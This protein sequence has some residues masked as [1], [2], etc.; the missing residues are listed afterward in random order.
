[1]SLFGLFP[2]E[3]V[4]IVVVSVLLKYIV[5][6]LVKSFEKTLAS[7]SSIGVCSGITGNCATGTGGGV[8]DAL[9]A[10]IACFNARFGLKSEITSGCFDTGEIVWPKF[11]HSSIADFS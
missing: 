10:S 9:K 7:I 11:N 3:F 5:S 4:W 8:D 6:F 2:I 1:M